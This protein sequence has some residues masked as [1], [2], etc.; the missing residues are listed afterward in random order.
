M[1][2]T[3]KW[4]IKDDQGM[5]EKFTIL[6]L[7]YTLNVE[8]ELLSPQHWSAARK[9]TSPINETVEETLHNQCTLFWDQRKHLRTIPMTI[10]LALGCT[11]FQTF[12]AECSIQDDKIIALDAYPSADI[13]KSK[14]LATDS[15]IPTIQALPF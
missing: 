3:I 1:K 9:D 5:V 15:K 4:K 10:N 2:G 7:Y 12:C 6:N 8:L 13:N 14:A 11:K